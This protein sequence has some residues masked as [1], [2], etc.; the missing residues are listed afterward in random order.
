MDG[1]GICHAKDAK[2]TFDWTGCSYKRGG[3]GM[4]LGCSELGPR[5]QLLPQVARQAQISLRGRI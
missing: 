4:V 2:D 1:R 3:V 5:Q